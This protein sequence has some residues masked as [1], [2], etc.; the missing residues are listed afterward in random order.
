MTSFDRIFAMLPLTWL[1][2]A[3][4]V[5]FA[6]TW[7]GYQWYADHSD[8]V[9]PRLSRATRSGNAVMGRA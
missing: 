2:A 9:R 1:D 7:A 3:A 8:T 4:L 6:A 5:L